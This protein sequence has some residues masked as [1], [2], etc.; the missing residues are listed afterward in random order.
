MKEMTLPTPAQVQQRRDER[1][2]ERLT[3]QMGTDS[4]ARERALLEKLAASGLDA[5]ELA[6]A[7]IQMARGVES[8]FALAEIVEVAPRRIE[9][10]VISEA[11]P[12]RAAI[13]KGWQTQ[14]DIPGMYGNHPQEAGMVRLRMNLGETHGL[15]PRDVVGAIAGEVGIPGQ[16]IGSIEIREHYS[17]VDVAEKHVNRV[18]RESGGKYFLRGK[19]VILTL[20]G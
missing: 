17:F 8:S 11:R 3:A 9:K 19:P 18:L 12:K 14:D 10:K 20:A 7:A 5:L 16:A 1:F 6:A 13:R 2:V 15:R 4:V